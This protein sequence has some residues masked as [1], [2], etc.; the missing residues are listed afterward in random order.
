MRLATCAVVAGTLLAALGGSSAAHAYQEGT[1]Q[2]PARCT[3]TIRLAGTLPALDQIIVDKDV[4]ACGDTLESRA[5]IVGSSKGVANAIVTIEGISAGKPI[6]AADSFS[7]A[8]RGCQYEPRVQVVPVGAR[9]AVRNDDPILHNT[10]A[11]FGDTQSLFNIALPIQDLQV[12]KDLSK[13]GLVRLECDAGHTWMRGYVLV[14]EHPY[15]AVTDE[16][17]A[18]AI[19][20][21]PPGTYSVKVWHETL[22]SQT[23]EVT[24]RPTE[25]TTLEFDLLPAP[26]AT[27]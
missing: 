23:R 22:G 8:N 25:T 24:F 1:V 3:G 4:T 19:D 18:F 20:D 5:L 16:S 15:Y 14:S 21:V 10:H 9:I 2:N 12:K 27:K 13:A 11:Y 17:G 7:I 6:A 26:P